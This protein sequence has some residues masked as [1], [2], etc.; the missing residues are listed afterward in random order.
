MG[1]DSPRSFPVGRKRV[2]VTLYEVNRD[3]LGDPFG[4]S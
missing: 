2:P 1:M 4:A 3:E